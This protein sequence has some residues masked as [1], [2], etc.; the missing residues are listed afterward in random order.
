M[1]KNRFKYIILIGLFISCSSVKDDAILNKL[2]DLSNQLNLK[3]CSYEVTVSYDTEKPSEKEFVVYYDLL[4]TIKND[5]WVDLKNMRGR[6]M[7]ETYCVIDSL[8]QNEKYSIYRVKS[9]VNNIESEKAYSKD[10]LE[11]AIQINTKIDS[12]FYS[13]QKDDTIGFYDFFDHNF[14]SDSSIH[15]I[16]NLFEYVSQ[17]GEIRSNKLIGFDI[18]TENRTQR[19]VILIDRYVI[20]GNSDE[21]YSFII[22]K[23]NKKIIYLNMES[24]MGC[25]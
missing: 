17:C 2:K 6:I 13:V 18:G 15:I 11:L 7:F 5:K 10:E 14:I 4:D 24:T 21:C 9:R 16:L 22:E 23:E 12:F 3:N 25:L 8:G 19:K 20:R 1:R